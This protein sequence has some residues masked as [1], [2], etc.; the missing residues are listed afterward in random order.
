MD[1]RFGAY[2]N[3]MISREIQYAEGV[4]KYIMDGGMFLD[5]E[6]ADETAFWKSYFEDYIAALKAAMI[7]GNVEPPR[8]NVT[9]R[10]IGRP[11][12]MQSSFL[13]RNRM[14]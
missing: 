9:I 4:L 14:P 3:T 11:P 6:G 2:Y 13:N 12:L 7:P 1:K 5:D 8:H 10:Y